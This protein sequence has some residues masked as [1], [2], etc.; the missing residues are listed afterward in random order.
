MVRYTE[1]QMDASGITTEGASTLLAGLFIKDPASNTWNS[2][3]Q[4]FSISQ[5]SGSAA[6][7]T[8]LAITV[9]NV[10][11]SGQRTTQRPGSITI[12]DWKDGGLN[13]RLTDG[14]TPA[15]PVTT[16]TATGDLD[17]ERD[18]NGNLTSA[19]DDIGNLI[20]SGT[21]APNR[22]DYLNGSTG[23]DHIIASGG[24][25]TISP[26]RI[27]TVN[28]SGLTLAQVEQAIR[29]RWS[30]AT[31]D[32]WI[33]GGAGRD[34][35]QAGPGNDL[36]EGGG[37][38]AT[39]TNIGGD[40]IAAGAGDDR[41]YANVKIATST[42]IAQ[43]ETD[44]ASNLKGAFINA[45]AGDDLVIGDTG[46]DALSGG[47]GSDT[48]S[49]GA[50]ADNLWG[51]S[52]LQGFT[53]DEWSITRRVTPWTTSDGVLNSYD[54]SF[55]NATGLVAEAS[56]AADWAFGQIDDME[57]WYASRKVSGPARADCGSDK[58]R[59]GESHLCSRSDNRSGSHS[60]RLDNWK[61]ASTNGFH[62]VH[63]VSFSRSAHHA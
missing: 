43:G 53:N 47:A 22:A 13:I 36:I 14:K 5:S 30:T 55:N 61:P 46:A 49:G 42:A 8:D 38:N 62:D 18:A 44:T 20:V 27:D 7:R 58:P 17:P 19:R 21:A 10:N 6:G 24:D 28:T 25:D 9:Y 56:G 26:L 60:T 41:I 40:R 29:E 34:L 57:Q 63:L 35:I 1:Q 32:D 50:G 16:R 11:A 45:L 54:F 4:K 39:G 33:E 52:N 31:A 15:V 51:D 12:K 2:L 3:D 23:A 37:G 59:K 48:L